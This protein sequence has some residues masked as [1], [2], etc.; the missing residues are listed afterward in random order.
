MP[1]FSHEQLADF[2]LKFNEENPPIEIPDEVTDDVDNDCDIDVV[3]K[4]V[5][6]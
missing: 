5:E 6:E 2:D 4:E 1:E 3:K